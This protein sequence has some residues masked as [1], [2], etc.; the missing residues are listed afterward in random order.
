MAA[1]FPEGAKG[2]AAFFQDT[3][4][5][6]RPTRGKYLGGTFSTRAILQR[7]FALEGIDYKGT[8][9]LDFIVDLVNGVLVVT[10]MWTASTDFRPILVLNPGKATTIATGRS[11]FEIGPVVL[12]SNGDPNHISIDTHLIGTR[13]R[14]VVCEEVKL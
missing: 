7:V 5:S 3:T 8:R 9:P 2:V 10:A 14:Q 13:G 12:V 4:K 6:D 1:G 11:Y